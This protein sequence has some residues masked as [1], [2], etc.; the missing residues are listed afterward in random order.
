MKHMFSVVLAL[1]LLNI[2]SLAQADNF[3]LFVG[4]MKTLALPQIDR[5]AVGNGGLVSTSIMDNGELLVLAEKAGDTEIQIWL[6]DG[7]VIAHKFYIIPANTARNVAEVRSIVGRVQGLSIR[8][9]GSNII[10]KGAIG[11]KA[12][13]MLEKVTKVYTNVI[14]LTSVASSKDLAKVL[15]DFPNIKVRDSGDKIVISGDVSDEDKGF[16]E[17]IKAS[18]PELVDLTVSGAT[19]MVYMSVQ[20]TELSN[21]VSENL[22]IQWSVTSDETSGV[23]YTTLSNLKGAITGG[24]TGSVSAAINAA[25]SDGEALILASPT[26]SASSGSEANFFS[27]G[28]FPIKILKDGEPTI[29]FKDYGLS[30]KINPVI[31]SNGRITTAIETELSDIDNSVAVDGVPGL[32]SRKTDTQ[33]SLLP[34]Q[35]F[36]ISGLV[37]R[38]VGRDESGLPFLRKVPI[39]GALFKSKSFSDKKSNLVIFITPQL[40]TPQSEI[41]QKQIKLAENMK[42]KMLDMSEFNLEIVE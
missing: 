31:E 29:E 1:L 6:K 42:V 5:V 8:Q 27:G 36:A 40:V 23:K 21:K 37:N 19:P 22:G 10:L 35:T 7:A 9:V 13:A 18:Y 28:S 11:H 3:R 17:A 4:Q 34:G 30:L 25:I 26:L 33:V 20:I 2:S 15:Q 38:N 39:L 41:N 14:N 32:I 12:I 16:I 24:L